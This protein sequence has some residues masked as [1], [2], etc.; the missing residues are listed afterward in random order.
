[1][2]ADTKCE[3]LSTELDEVRKS[4]E[5]EVKQMGLEAALTSKMLRSELR[6]EDDGKEGWSGI[7]S[8]RMSLSL[9]SRR[10]HR[11]QRSFQ[12]FNSPQRATKR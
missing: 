5:A 8:R 6:V 10:R 7:A 12:A 3:Q 11:R 1:M 9:R 4:R 2:A